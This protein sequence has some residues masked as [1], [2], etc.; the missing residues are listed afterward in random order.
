MLRQRLIPILIALLVV[1]LGLVALVY[2]PRPSQA[3]GEPVF[4]NLSTA[5]II[6]LTIA[7]SDGKQ[8]KLTRHG[9]GWVLPEAGDYPAQNDRIN[10]LLEKLVGLKTGRLVAETAASHARLQVAEDAFVRRIELETVRGERYT[11]YLGTAPRAGATHFRLQGQDR[12]YLAADLAAFDAMVEP[13]SYIDTTYVS[14]PLADIA[15]LRVEN[16]RGVL[17]FSKEGE[18]WKLAGLAADQTLDTFLV[19]SLVGRLASLT[20]TRPLGTA[21]DASTLTAWGL[22][23]PAATIT[24]TTRPATG[25]GKTHVLQIGAKDAETNNY[26]VKYSE[27]PYYVQIAGFSLDDFVTKTVADFVATPTPTPIPTPA[28]TPTPTP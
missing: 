3:T 25:E 17:D 10:P 15:A 2:W 7:D 5:D 1:Q 27:S 4:P 9:E 6:A 20:M 11:L 8:L 12:V 24:I 23:P 13:V 19:Q 28:E 14:I 26:Y 21:P 18:T 22:N 16:A